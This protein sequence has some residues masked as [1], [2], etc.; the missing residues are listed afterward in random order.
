MDPNTLTPTEA[1]LTEAQAAGILN[2]APATLTAW[3]ATKRARRP[4]HCKVGGA[5]RYRRAD[6]DRFID[7]S[8]RK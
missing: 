6:I 4:I 5:V 2:I 1:L 7:E 8:V 3:R